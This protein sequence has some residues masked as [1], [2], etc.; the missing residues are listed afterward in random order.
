MNA[1]SVCVIDDFGP[2]PAVETLSVSELGEIVRRA[3]AEGL[4]VYPVGGQSMLGIGYPPT[5]KGLAV[6]VRRLD[7]VVDYPARDMTITVG[8]GVT[9]GRLQEILRAENQRLPVDVP[10]PGR[11]TLGGVLAVNTS[12]PRRYGFGTFRDY[13]I[14]LSAVNDEGQEI[15]AGGRVVKNVAGYDLCKL[16]VG[17][18]GTLGVISQ[19]TLKLRP[20]PEEQAVV[21][22]PCP[23]DQLGP[24]L[25]RLHA[26][27]TRPVCLDFLNPAAVRAVNQQ[28]EM[29]LPEGSWVGLGGF[30]DNRPAV[31]WQ[32]EQLGR[33]LGDG[34]RPKVRLGPAAGQF[35]QVLTDLRS[36]PAAVLTFKANLLP[37]AV[38][39]FCR[40]AASLPE[41]LLLH[42]H[43][44]SGIVTGHA[45]GD[46]DA[47][48]A[49][50]LLEALSGQ[51]AAAAGNVVV[52]RCPPAWKPTLPLW[53]RARGDLALMRAVKEK[54]DPRGLFNPGRFLPGL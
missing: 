24:F 38:A 50:A 14:G 13:V 19:V 27:R 28:A 17:S 33:E 4:A 44:G 53:G 49:A 21:V 52:L 1:A 26:S 22:C 37:H 45:L 16:F 47:G 25:D 43:A 10:D 40:A 39:S 20:V 41:S 12:G 34:W 35:W 30:E 29:A 54:L 48:R 15:K 31:A 18:L 42:A 8:A 2:L 5:K 23:E 6:D 3:A 11:A 32:V 7:A 51:A 46:L 36:L 9:F